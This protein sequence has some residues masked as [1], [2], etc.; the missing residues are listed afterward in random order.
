MKPYSHSQFEALARK[1]QEELV[2]QWGD[3]IGQSIHDERP[4]HACWLKKDFAEQGLVFYPKFRKAIM[5]FQRRRRNNINSNMLTITLRSEHIPYNLFFPLMQEEMLGQA[6]VFFRDL[7]HLD[8]IACITGI[9]IE[10]APSPKTDYLN[11]G[12]SFDVYV[13]YIHNDGSKGGIGIEVKYTER[14]Y[15]IRKG[16]PEWKHTHDELGNVRLWSPYANPTYNANPSLKEC[17]YISGADEL[18]VEDNLRQI[19]RN[20]ILGESMRRKKDIQHFDTVIL[21]PEGNPHFFSAGE[22]YMEVLTDYGKRHFHLVTYEQFFAMLCKH[23]RTSAQQEW[24]SY[25]YSRYLFDEPR[26]TFP[27][28]VEGSDIYD[29]IFE[30]A[31]SQNHGA[32]QKVRFIDTDRFSSSKNRGVS[33]AL[34]NAFKESCLYKLYKEHQNELIVCVRNNYINLYYKL[35]SFGKISLANNGDIRCELDSYFIDKSHNPWDYK[36]QVYD[37]YETLK[38]LASNKKETTNEKVAQHKL[39]LQNNSSLTSEWYCVDV[40]WARLFNDIEEKKAAGLSGRFDFIAVSKSSPHRVAIIELKYGYDSLKGESGVFKHVED[41]MKFKDDFEYRGRK[42]DYYGGLKTDIC[43]IL[44]NFIQLGIDVPESLRTLQETDFADEPEFKVILLDNNRKSARGTLPKQTMAAYL[45]S[46]NSMN[47]NRWECKRPAAASIMGTY[48]FDVLDKE[49]R[50]PM[51]FIFSSMKVDNLF[52]TD[53]LEDSSYEISKPQ[54]KISASS[55]IPSGG[56]TNIK[57]ISGNMKKQDSLQ[58]FS[59]YIII[60]MVAAILLFLAYLFH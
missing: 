9:E 37:R 54:A 18:L 43:N 28:P 5:D 7:L 16:N 14:E 11:D 57:P 10:Y 44:R 36:F 4:N 32:E 50:L 13:S 6:S 55:I 45:F 22:E 19:W 2:R 53:I 3:A 33:D 26:P 59:L 42:L 58:D 23:F 52:V 17:L 20:H 38:I 35:N 31:Q 51:T 48:G 30:T 39:F 34:I 24:I 21:F 12:T 49:S 56:T 40:E 47:Y 8:Y 25:L 1:H 29:A 15:P 46:P 41:F 27:T 60:S